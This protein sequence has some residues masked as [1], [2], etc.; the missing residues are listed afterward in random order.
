MINGYYMVLHMV[1]HQSSLN[2]TSKRSL[3]L[4]MKV[5]FPLEPSIASKLDPHV[6]LLRNS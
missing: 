2:L 5:A 6:F 1:H 3:M 4:Q